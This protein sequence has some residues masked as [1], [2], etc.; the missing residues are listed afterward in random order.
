MKNS[1]PAASSSTRRKRVPTILQ[2]SN[3]ECGA[4]CLAMVLSFHGR[5]TSVADLHE[6]ISTGRDGVRA[7]VIA[8]VARDFGLRTRSYSGQPD[9]FQHL[10]LPAI[11]HWN[12]NHYILVERWSEK[13]IEIVDPAIG[14]KSLT[15]SEF[16]AGFTGVVMTFEPSMSFARRAVKSDSPWKSYLAYALGVSGIRRILLQILVS[17]VVLQLLGLVL[18]VATKIIVDNV[19]PSG[20][21]DLLTIMA[22]GLAVIVLMQLVTIYL[23]HALFIY[24]QARLDSQMMLGFFEHMLSLPL[25]FFQQRTSGDLIMRLNSNSIIRLWLRF[26]M[27]AS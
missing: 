4:A 8:K 2:N 24:L 6:C 9:H 18:P 11:V 15:P 26:S 19:L 27:V 14:R 22:L 23:R 1:S 13:E 10:Q 5:Q 16:D 7:S 3:A 25:P 12:F 20:L 21:E 17:S